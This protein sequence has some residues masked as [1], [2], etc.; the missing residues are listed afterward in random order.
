MGVARKTIHNSVVDTIST[1][2]ERRKQYSDCS[3]NDTIAFGKSLNNKFDH[4]TKH[5][6]DEI[7]IYQK[8]KTKETSN[9]KSFLKQTN[10]ALQDLRDQTSQDVKTYTNKSN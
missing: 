9:V 1:G 3:H 5:S 4:M 6:D 2:L 8:W 10:S 7:S